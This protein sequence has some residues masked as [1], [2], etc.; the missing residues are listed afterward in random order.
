MKL[1]PF[2]AKYGQERNKEQNNENSD[3]FGV[4]FFATKKAS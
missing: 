4:F 2:L 3:F 1:I